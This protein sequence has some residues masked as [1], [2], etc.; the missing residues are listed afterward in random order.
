MKKKLQQTGV[1]LGSLLVSSLLACRIVP[2]PSPPN[3]LLQPK[4]LKTPQQEV[5]DSCRPHWSCCE[6]PAGKR[7]HE[8]Y[9]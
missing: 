9:R 3:L 4:V 2:Q 8:C 5:P 6:C 1:L 7:C